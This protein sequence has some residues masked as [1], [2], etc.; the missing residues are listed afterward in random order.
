MAM[1][2]FLYRAVTTARENSD[3]ASGLQVVAGPQPAT[4][5]LVEGNM[6]DGSEVVLT[7]KEGEEGAE[8]GEK[9]AS[10]WVDLATALVPAE[11]LAISIAAVELQTT[12]DEA[13]GAVT[14]TAS[15]SALT[16]QF[17][18]LMLLPAA[19][20]LVGRENLRKGD[21]GRAAIPCLAFVAWTLLQPV[22]MWTAVEKTTGRTLET[23]TEFVVAA[24]LVLI[25]GPAAARLAK[26]AD[27]AERPGSPAGGDA[28]G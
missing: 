18:I 19:I 15:D 11:V 17:L 26:A 9:K 8:G 16:W 28:A 24:A 6:A 13:T 5:Y 7:P 4:R 25:L 14:F 23:G 3:P 12:T 21:W 2:T 1:S 27:D 10:K 20:F 22:S